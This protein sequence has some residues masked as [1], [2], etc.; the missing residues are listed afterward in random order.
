MPTITTRQV[1]DADGKKALF[2]TSVA[3]V[4]VMV[5]EPAMVGTVW[6]TGV[7]VELLRLSA[8]AV[9]VTAV[10]IV[11]VTVAVNIMLCVTVGSCLTCVR[12]TCT[13]DGLLGATIIKE[14]PNFVLSARDIAS[15]TNP[16][17][18]RG[19]VYVTEFVV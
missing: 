13:L 5:Y 6:E 2:V 11:P 12:V 9:Q 16:G 18:S 8:E 14:V 3:L 10:F 15:S 1:C 7:A 19:A 17:T 4:A